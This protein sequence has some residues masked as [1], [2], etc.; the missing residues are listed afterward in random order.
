M[1]K[2]IAH[3]YIIR[4]NLIALIGV[5]LCLYFIYHA[6]YGQRSLMR[7]SEVNHTIETMSLEGDTLHTQRVALGDR[8]KML[9]PGS[10]NKDLLEERVR[11]M[12]GYSDSDEVVLV[13]K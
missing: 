3:R 6:V 11:L 4:Q 7:L 5:C 2:F 1:N 13:R 10:I 9:R 12:L 8:V